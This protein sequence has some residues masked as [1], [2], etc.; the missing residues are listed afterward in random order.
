[1]FFA[2][3]RKE[4]GTFHPD[5]YSCLISARKICNSEVDD[6]TDAGLGRVKFFRVYLGVEG[7]LTD[8]YMEKEENKGLGL[9]RR[10]V[11]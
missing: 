1:M 5:V 10:W 11:K 4:N 7:E 8:R 2:K 9:E 3:F 6:R